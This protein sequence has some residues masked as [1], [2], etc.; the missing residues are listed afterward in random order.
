M[1]YLAIG[2]FAG[3]RHA[4][5][6]RLDWSDVKLGQGHIEITAGKAKTAQRRIV[7]IQK[8]LAAWL[9][10]RAHD[11]GHLCSGDG[12][13]FLNK[14]TAIAR[15]CQIPWPH[16]G[17][18]HSFASYRLAQCKNAAEV[19]LEMG[20]TPRMIFQHYRELVTPAN[21]AKWWQINP[22]R[23]SRSHVS[24]LEVSIVKP[25]NP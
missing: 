23:K 18:R 6:M 11:R 21:A 24:G 10:P 25:P 12:S 1:P 15:Q 9:K 14:V 22:S 5:L 7:P 16:N 2:A 4:E 17:L 19:S 8:N 13:R 3:L 20:N